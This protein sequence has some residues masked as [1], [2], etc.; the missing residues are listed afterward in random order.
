[1]ELKKANRQNACKFDTWLP[2]PGYEGIYEI[3]W[4]GIVRNAQTGHILS[5]GRAKAG[6][7]T[8][9]LSNKD[10]AKKTHT[11]HRLVM[12]TWSPDGQ[13][14]MV[15]HIDGIK[16]N[17]HIANLEWCTR[18]ENE[19][20]GHKIGLK[21]PVNPA[22]GIIKYDLEWNEIE[23]FRT[24]EEVPGF[25]SGNLCRA[26]KKYYGKPYRGFLWSFINN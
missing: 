11:V 13:K 14:E 23:R 18:S 5:P 4:R 16:S 7:M 1:M 9:G 22:K 3:H 15:N 19:I 24:S 10:K 17:N 12:L 8:V 20:H 25:H 6:Y 2:V 21:K 26:I